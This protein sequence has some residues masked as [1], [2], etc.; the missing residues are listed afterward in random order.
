MAN[1]WITHN[2]KMIYFM[3]FGECKSV[4]EAMAALLDAHQAIV[5]APGKILALSNYDSPAA[6]AKEVLDRLTDVAKTGLFQQKLEK[7]AVIGIEG[8]KKVYYNSFLTLSADR[9][10]KQFGTKEEALDWLVS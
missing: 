9:S 5:K 3:N 7:T 2:G 8:M 4:E 10:S 1:S 6:S